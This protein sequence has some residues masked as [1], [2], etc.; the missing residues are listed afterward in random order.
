MLNTIMMLS[1]ATWALARWSV[2][3]VNNNE[4]PHCTA[5]HPSI[6]ILDWENE[7]GALGPCCS[8]DV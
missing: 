7:G 6:Q 1:I 3:K 5:D 2:P 8:G 4:S